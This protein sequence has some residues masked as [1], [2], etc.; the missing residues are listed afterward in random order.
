[1]KPLK[2]DENLPVFEIVCNADDTT[3]IRLLSLVSKPAIE[4]KGQFFSEAE[5]KQIEFTAQE[6]KQ[7]IVGPAM[8][9]NRK[10]LRKDNNGNPYYVL[11]TADTIRMMVE[12]FNSQNDNR[13]LNV[14]H[15][16]T[17]VNGYIMQNWIVEDSYY[18]KSKHYG[19][20]LPVGSWFV[21]VKIEDTNFWNNEV[22]ELGKYGFSIEGL[23]GEIPMENSII[24]MESIIDALTEDELNALLKDIL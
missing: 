10:I 3:G 1:M 9:P 11:F 15:S 18:D 2:N 8:I 14:D 6:D 12:K 23:M 21:E 19:Y 7:M 5:L 16:S 13:R 4:M 22:K 24:N 20:S 17:M